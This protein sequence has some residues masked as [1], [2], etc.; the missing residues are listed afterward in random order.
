MLSKILSTV[1]F[2]MNGKRVF[3]FATTKAP[4]LID[5]YISH[6]SISK[7]SISSVILHQANI[8]IV[9][10]ISEILGIDMGLFF[11]NLQKYGN[12]SSASLFIA[13]AESFEQKIEKPKDTHEILCSF[14]G[15]LSWGVSCLKY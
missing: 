13:L 2:E 5:E 11:T 1:F 7:K 4:L 6:F 10:K 8:N 9:K 15:C 3:E 14:G 12:T